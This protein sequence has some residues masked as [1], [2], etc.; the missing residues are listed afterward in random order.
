MA[1]QEKAVKGAPDLAK[2]EQEEEK[3]QPRAPDGSRRLLVLLHGEKASDPMVR[4]AIARLRSEGHKLSVRVT[5]EA[6]DVDR[7]VK[8]ALKLRSA[9][10]LVAA[11]GDGTVCEVIAALLQHTGGLADTR[12]VTAP[13]GARDIVQLAEGEPPM[14]Q[15]MSVAVLPMG[16]SNDFAATTGIPQDP[17][18]ALLLATQDSTANP[19]DV[20]L[21]NGRVFM[22]TGTIGASADIG[23]VTSSKLK[24]MLGPAAFLFTGVRAIGSWAPVSSVLRFP[25]LPEHGTMQAHKAADENAGKSTEK[26]AGS[27]AAGQQSGGGKKNNQ[28][29]GK[30][31]SKP[32][33]QQGGQGGKDASSSAGGDDKLLRR[34]SQEVPADQAHKEQAQG[35]GRIDSS[36][37]AEPAG[38]PANAPE[39]T[40]DA[41]DTT[42]SEVGELVGVP[43]L[44]LTAA[45][46]RQIAS[47]VAIAPNAVLDDGM[48]DIV[49]LTGT[50]GETVRKLV[51]GVFKQG[52]HRTKLV[53]TLLRL[54]W[55]EIATESGLDWSLDGEP[56]PD[57]ADSFRFSL[58]HRA[59][60]FHLPDTRM[61]VESQEAVESSAVSVTTG[62]KH[63]HHRS[64]PLKLPRG[65]LHAPTVA[66]MVGGVV[67][68]RKKKDW[69]AVIRKN[70]LSLAKTLAVASVGAYTM[71][72]WHA[73]HGSN[74]V[75]DVARKGA[76]AVAGAGH[77]VGK[78]IRG[79]KR[80]S[81]DDKKHHKAIHA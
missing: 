33:A 25:N 39:A 74:P 64:N 22:N 44:H 60:R 53:P 24:K 41:A 42:G 79:S 46:N 62:K 70:L 71:H 54:P 21:L 8:E 4:A 5:F 27:T 20:G 73:R 66:D 69:G 77:K 58:L 56:Q 48:L 72:L 40:K 7:L 9:D 43:L 32:T 67:R 18:E 6:G 80:N 45:N 3:P 30:D 12:N 1:V 68:F 55:L 29:G 35:K 19:I 26:A 34:L 38:T 57:K 15:Q 63:K 2:V 13:E 17:Y 76:A 61:L 36:V 51:S 10:T 81:S 28:K 37:A 75:E 16:T 65:R 52:A 78:T 11:G 23:K 14:L 49:Y 31:S 59:V 47:M 50:P